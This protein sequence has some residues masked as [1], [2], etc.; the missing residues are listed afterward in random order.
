VPVTADF[1]RCYR[2]IAGRDERFDGWLFVGVH[3]TGIYCRPSCPAVTPKRENVCFYPT[4]A[5]AQRAGLRA[6]KRCRPDASPGS[7]EWSTRSDAT[8]RAMRLIADGVVDREGVRG[9]ARRLAF[10]ERHLHRMLVDE[11]GAGPLAIARAQ[12][13]QT[14]RLL[15]ETSDLTFTEIAFA[16]GFGS[17][18]AFNTTIRDTLALTPTEL[19]RRAQGPDGAR[20]EGRLMLRLPLRRPFAAGRLLSFLAARSVAGVEAADD[21]G[22]SRTLRLPHAAGSVRL[23][24]HDD[25]VAATLRLADLR[26]LGAAVAQSRRLLDLDADPRAVHDALA[27]DPWI[28]DLVARAP[29]L[30]APGSADPH[31]VVTRAIVGQQISV[32]GART[33]M[34]RLCEI[35]GEA[36]RNG[37]A[38]LTR[39]WPSAQALADADPATLPMPHARAQALIGA[40]RALAAGDLALDPGVD[41][42]AARE[43]LTA[44]PG[45]GPW[46]AS[47]IALRALNDPDVF[48]AS[49]LGARQALAR[50][51]HP[52]DAGSI[53]R[54]S[55]AWRPWRSYATHYLWDSLTLTSP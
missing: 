43:A 38:R 28:G 45:I 20:T 42:S 50:L 44:L 55:A 19:R 27:A 11:L 52:A 54:T 49:D 12:R 3:S 37:D 46:T 17:L 1:D 5:A 6:C 33:V 36:Y 35:H 15:I 40:A 2:A 39:L 29:G 41:R 23:E 53:A 34:A 13:A 21:T 51:G 32:A 22:Y 47:Y 18:R 14:A 25:H 9:L 10:S 31:E 7:P 4:A 24:L 26:D 48:L 8:A 30:R 16:A